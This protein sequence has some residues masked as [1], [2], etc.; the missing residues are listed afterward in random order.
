MND[1]ADQIFPR[2]FLRAVI[3]PPSS[4]SV[5]PQQRRSAKRS[6]RQGTV[7]L[8][9]VV[10]LGALIGLVAWA[11]ETGRMWQ[12]KSQLQVV[13]DVASLAGVANLLTNNFQSVDQAAART[14]ATSYGPLHEV[15]GTT[16]A[17]PDSDV[18]AGSW[19][20]ATRLF[21]PLLG[22]TDPNLVRAVRVRTRR[23]AVANGPVPTILG[24]AIGVP[25][26]EVNS[27]AV[28]YWGFAGTGGPGVADLP[29]ALDCCAISNNTP[30]S[31]C[32]AD[33][34]SWISGYTPNECSLAEGGTA[35]C[36]EFHSTLQQNACWTV[37]DGDSPAI[38]TPNLLDIVEDGNLTDIDGP[39]Y[40]D[41][42]D[43]VPVIGEIKHRFEGTNGYSPAEGTDTNGGGNVDSWVVTLP[44]MECQNPGDRCAGGDAQDVVA[45]VCF[46][47]HEVLGP[48]QQI[49]KGSFVC[50][51]DPRC[52]NAGLGPGGTLPGALSSQFPVIV[53]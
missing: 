25:S 34:C 23:D 40:V 9:V 36:L 8:F 12:A 27:E 11:T 37:F 22:S 1:G 4:A 29:I 39:I 21:T 49:I 53:H 20:L 35:T 44:V 24:G 32:T 45:F 15:L 14:A 28:A 13:A 7:I 6:E 18:D 52:D 41:N 50:P 3:T 48:P 31:S 43:K 2:S 46:D 30:S 17:I 42:G 33:Y 47:I 5:L 26:L 38:S 51:T 10:A 19:D 16:L